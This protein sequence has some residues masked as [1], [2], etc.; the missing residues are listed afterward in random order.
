MVIFKSSQ[1]IVTV[2][3]GA[4]ALKQKHAN[5]THQRTMVATRRDSTP[6]ARRAAHRHL[7]SLGTVAAMVE[8]MVAALPSPAQYRLCDRRAPALFAPP[9]PAPFVE[10]PSCGRHIRE[11]RATPTARYGLIGSRTIRRIAAAGNSAAAA[12]ATHPEGV[13]PP[14][15]D[16]PVVAN[17]V[18]AYSW[19][20]V[21]L[22]AIHATDFI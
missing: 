20:I 13:A 11:A 10:A 4:S 8:Q 18:S 7:S 19:P 5:Y 14:R 22:D 15:L 9:L 3:T 16:S 17:S 21:W 6:S 12:E 1:D 2:M